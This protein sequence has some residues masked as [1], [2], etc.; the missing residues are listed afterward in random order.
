MEIHRLVTRF[1]SWAEA[2]CRAYR[3]MSLVADIVELH[4]LAQ[5]RDAHERGADF[6]IVAVAADQ[7]ALDEVLAAQRAHASAQGKAAVEA[8][9][10]LMGYPTCCVQA[11]LARRARK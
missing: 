6:A 1:R 11:F 2:L 10:A 4:G 9:G 7:A 8:M 5:G 3:A